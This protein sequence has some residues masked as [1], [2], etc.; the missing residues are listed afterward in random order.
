MNWPL[1][2][3]VVRKLGLAL[4][5]FLIKPIMFCISN[6]LINP[7]YCTTINSTQQ[8]HTMSEKQSTTTASE[9]Q[10]QATEKPRSLGEEPVREEVQCGATYFKKVEDRPVVIEKVET[11]V[12]HHNVEREYVVETRATGVERELRDQVTAE[13]VDVREK[14]I[15]QAEPANPCDL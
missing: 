8:A 3:G 14:V 12:E 2:G 11:I 13:V 4:V 9:Q 1:M 10:Q 15:S 7:K 5:L 6:S